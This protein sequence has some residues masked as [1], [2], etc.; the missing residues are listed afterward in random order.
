MAAETAAGSGVDAL[1]DALAA[2]APCAR[3]AP[4]A[5]PEL[6][7]IGVGAARGGCALGGVGDATALLQAVV[8]AV[9]PE[10]EHETAMRPV[11]AIRT[12]LRT[13]RMTPPY[14]DLPSEQNLVNARRLAVTTA[15][16]ADAPRTDATPQCLPVANE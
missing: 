14:P 12:T 15:T 4:W 3:R 16:Q 5:W 10:P 1:L 8:D 6:P 2:G 13:R 11:A 9:D 7:G